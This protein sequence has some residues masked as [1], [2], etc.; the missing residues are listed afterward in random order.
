MLSLFLALSLNT[1]PVNA[2]KH[3]P[4]AA[5]AA[6]TVRYDNQ[7]FT[8]NGKDLVIYSG[9][10][11]YFRAPKPLWR[12]RLQKIKAAHFNCVETYIAWNWHERTEG[13]V[14]L[15]DFEDWLKLCEEMGLYVIARPGPYICAEWD[16][17]GYPSWLIAKG[18]PLRTGSPQDVQ[19]SKHWFDAVLPVI[20]RHQIQ[21]GGA[22]IMCQIE[23]EYDYHP[24]V[25][26]AEKKEYVRA[27]YK[28]AK[29][30]G[31]EVP[32]ITCWTRP[33]RDESDPDMREII[34]TCNFYPSW[35]I[36][37]TVPQLAQLKSQQ[38]NAPIMV[39]ELQGGWFSGF[40]GKLS[41][42]QP[43]ITAEQENALIKTM[44]ASG[45]TA[46]NYYML[47]G[48]TNFG[49]WGGK[50]M[51]TSYD[52]AAPI[53]EPGGLW[54]KYYAVK[55]AG[56]FNEM[57]GPRLARSAAM[58]DPATT[59]M[60]GVS[61]TERRSG[62]LGFIFLRNDRDA[63]RDGKVEATDP[64]TGNRFSLSVHLEPRGAKILT[65][66]AQVGKHFVHRTSG[67]ISGIY[68]LGKRDVVILSG[69]PGQEVGL[70]LDTRSV[71]PSDEQQGWLSARVP[72]ANSPAPDTLLT[73]PDGT[74]VIIT[75]SARA[76]RM[77]DLPAD[78]HAFW[79]VISDFYQLKEAGATDDRM[80]FDVDLQ[81]GSHTVSVPLPKKASRVLIGGASVPFDSVGDGLARFKVEAGNTDI[82]YIPLTTVH[83]TK[84]MWGGGTGWKPVTLK[85]LDELGV[86]QNGY[87]RYRTLFEW[88]NE[89][90]LVLSGFATDPML[91]ALNGVPAAATVSEGGNAIHVDLTKGAK[92]GVNRVEVLYENGGR[93]NFGGAPIWEKKGLKSATL[94]MEREK[95]TSLTTWKFKRG[96][97]PT[98][99]PAYANPRLNDSGWKSVG[100]GNIP[101]FNGYK[102]WGWYRTTLNLT[103]EDRT[104][105]RANL[106]FEG[107]DDNAVVYVNGQ[108]VGEHT[109][110]EGS[111]N[112]EIGLQAVVGE[113]SIV[114]AVENTDGPGGI[115]KP[116]TLTAKQN[117]APLGGWEMADRLEGEKKGWQNVTLKGPGW[118]KANLPERGSE[119]T[120]W[121]R[122]YRTSF[123]LP[124][125][126]GSR[127]TAPWKLKID[128]GG[129]ALIYLNGTLIG[130]YSDR[131]PQSEFYLPEC[132]MH[133]GNTPNV[134]SIAI[135]DGV[136]PAALKSLAVLPY[137]E[138]AVRKIS[139]AVEY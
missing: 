138:Y 7:C 42:E 72:E 28:I 77:A 129:E 2:V 20:R 112:I 26:E 47:F 117:G 87:T 27:L 17:G 82:P 32:I 102:G 9:A 94:Y 36:A 85:S 67:E 3:T 107:V 62:G 50:G 75:S 1:K 115:T 73:T 114:V 31:I 126:G 58:P 24:N 137:T 90:E 100:I 113:N 81:P 108:R 101:D 16:A 49:W 136:K 11:H 125:P 59:D 84:E 4:P 37:G 45:A 13:H 131:G 14:D 86:M 76:A 89:K 53:R 48:G 103:A 52:Y 60:E 133:T 74:L 128:A 124:N 21:S 110:W 66:N 68:Q 61:A 41:V 130:R 122:W 96:P 99:A 10:F 25:S 123:R 44:W 5:K 111:F 83:V 127:F 55:A 134:L 97:V 98:A 78:N 80:S 18:F 34:D 15:R 56:K 69:D 105:G 29:A 104:A 43:G 54:D 64:S 19:W 39:T 40:G 65:V 35:G 92:S 91:V 38:P 132:W 30:N 51:T 23:N 70:Q 71:S 57:F 120:N 22:I 12:D 6:G 106:F 139:I 135:R 33:A 8:I 119:P 88:H 93:P 95:G 109:G 79:P 116:V 118:M 121:V 46:T 63:A